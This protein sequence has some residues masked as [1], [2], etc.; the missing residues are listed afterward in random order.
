MAVKNKNGMLTYTDGNGNYQVPEVLGGNKLLGPMLYTP[1]PIN[2]SKIPGA[3]GNAITVTKAPASDTPTTDVVIP[4]T[5]A[6]EVNTPSTGGTGGTGS[7]GN[8]GGTGSSGNTGGNKPSTKPSPPVIETPKNTYVPS[9]PPE[10][11]KFRDYEGGNTGTG[12]ESALGTQYSW[13]KEGV[14]AA[15]IKYQ[16]EVLTAK[17]QALANRQTIEQNSTQYQQQ[18]DMMKYTDNQEA[19]KVGWTGGYVL[20]QRRQTEYLKASIQAQMYGA[21]ELQKYGYDSALAAARLSYDLNQ[22]EFA[23]KYY[24]DAVSVALQEAETTGT[25]ISAEIRDMSSQYNTATQ[26][27]N[28]ATSSQADRERATQ[29]KQTIDSWFLTNGLSKTGV[30]TF[31]KWQAEQAI[32]MQEQSYK[33]EMWSAAE[34]AKYNAAN[35]QFSYDNLEAQKQQWQAE[36]D[37]D[38]K[39]QETQLKQSAMDAANSLLDSNVSMDFVLDVNGEPI[40]DEETGSYKTIDFSK[41][42]PKDVIAYANRNNYTKEQVYGQ[43][44]YSVNDIV[45]KITN[46]YAVKDTSGNIT[47]F[48][49]GFIS[50]LQKAIQ[51]NSTFSDLK[52]ILNGYTYESYTSHV[53]YTVSIDNN[54]N[55]KVNTALNN[56]YTEGES[57]PSDKPT[58]DPNDKPI[59]EPGT[60]EPT[61]EGNQAYQK[62]TISV[63]EDGDKFTNNNGDRGSGNN[64]SLYYKGEILRVQNG[65][66]VIHGSELDKQLESLSNIEGSIARINGVLYVRDNTT[67]YVVEQRNKDDWNIIK[68]AFTLTYDS[69][70]NSTYYTTVKQGYRK[71]NINNNLDN[72]YWTNNKLG[73]IQTDWAGEGDD[74]EITVGNTNYTITVGW[75]SGYNIGSTQKESQGYSHDERVALTKEIEA[76]YPN[77]I[78]G[79]IVYYDNNYWIYSGSRYMKRK[80]TS[81]EEG[82][83]GIIVTGDKQDKKAKDAEKL[84]E[85]LKNR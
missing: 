77:A 42:S 81:M 29:V 72:S 60:N 76:K 79:D 34:T 41:M 20:D 68:N 84:L 32:H 65:P 62:S 15:N 8:T 23:H 48:K 40:Y 75:A 50:A 22:Q 6:P 4:E 54:G 25:Y 55:I 45:T 74:I 46:Q 13:D 61:D 80:N 2:T 52:E 69:T 73:K 56:S 35:L 26:I 66:Q 30:E 24:M 83:W 43:V 47:G 67:W 3:A 78:K 49:E 58:T 36:F 1:T 16:Q 57:E 82:G 37:R 28:D 17:Q 38:T 12:I 53:T 27:L 10:Y 18:V 7:S 19:E 14:N 31:A 21:M 64:F 9:T 85:A 5:N 44:D 71:N 39:F 51:E 59:V 63:N 11:E 33:L 70:P